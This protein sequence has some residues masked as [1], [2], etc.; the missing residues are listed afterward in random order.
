MLFVLQEINPQ[1]G[2]RLDNSWPW[3]DKVPQEDGYYLQQRQQRS[4]RFLPRTRTEHLGKKIYK[5]I[6]Q[7][8]TKI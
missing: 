2:T 5:I 8:F 7:N 1:T 3:N 4:P 6:I